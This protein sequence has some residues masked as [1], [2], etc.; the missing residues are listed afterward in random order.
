MK[1][2]FLAFLFTGIALLHFSCSEKN[3]SAPE[4]S[5]SD[6]VTNSLAKPHLTGTFHIDF[7]PPGTFPPY[8]WNGTIIINGVTYGLRFKSLAEDPPPPPPQAHVFDERFE[9][10]EDGHLGDL[11]Y[12]VLEGP[13]AGVL[14]YGN[15]K[16]VMNGEVEVANE[17]FGMWMGRNVHINGI[18]F[19]ATYPVLPD[20]C[21]GTF[22][23]N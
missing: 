19:W 7:L 14:N 16:F 17:P 20:Y 4:L 11:N 15:S 2:L 9:I 21:T 12:L 23:I 8:F 13:D 22:R 10:Y 18:C 1:R 3:P 6:Q 5:Q